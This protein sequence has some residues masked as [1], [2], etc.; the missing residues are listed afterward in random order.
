M[1][2]SASRTAPKIAHLGSIYTCTYGLLFFGTPHSGANK[3]RLLG[4]LQKLA[5]LATPK[6]AIQF[7]S[8]LLNALEQE[9]ETLQNITDQFTPLMANFRIFFFWEQEKLDL[10][11]TKEY[12]VEE[13]SAAPM[14]DGTER[15]GIAADHREM[16]QFDRNTLQGFRTAV[17]ALKRYCLDAPSVIEG[18]CMRAALLHND[19]LRFEALTML[20]S[21]QTWPARSDESPSPRSDLGRA[22]TIQGDTGRLIEGRRS[23]EM[24]FGDLSA[25]GL[26]QVAQL[27]S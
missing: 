24:R 22:W 5:A 11:Y 6:A 10:K 1:A 23:E 19:N 18:R 25:A 8:S 16:C 13:S 26:Q 17:S 3:A 9:S 21:I 14:V 7:E 12:I 2:Y 27:R 20:R 4:S 15:C